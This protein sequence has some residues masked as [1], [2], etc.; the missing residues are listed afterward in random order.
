[1]LDSLRFI[2]LFTY[3]L[4]GAALGGRFGNLHISRLTGY[5]LDP[6]QR[7][8]SSSSAGGYAMHMFD[9][10]PVGVGVPRIEWTDLYSR[11][12]WGDVPERGWVDAVFGPR[13][14]SIR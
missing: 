14:V 12:W 13:L 5:P 3:Q 11:R 4:D 1:M 10:V 8:V 9:G 6:A 7:G 2:V